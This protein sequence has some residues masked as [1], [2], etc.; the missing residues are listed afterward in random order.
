MT[1]TATLLNEGRDLI[2]GAQFESHT[3]TSILHVEECATGQPELFS[4]SAVLAK[5]ASTGIST[6]RV[7]VDSSF[8]VGSGTSW[9]PLTP[10][11]EFG[12]WLCRNI[13]CTPNPNKKNSWV[14]RITETNMGRVY[15]S[16]AADDSDDPGS[17]S[18]DQD[19]TVNWTATGKKQQAW[20]SQPELPEEVRGGVNPDN[21]YEANW[22]NVWDFCTSV[23]DLGGDDVAFGM[24]QPIQLTTRQSS[25][26][27]EWIVRAPIKDFDGADMTPYVNSND[28][29]P[30][31]ALQTLEAMV[32]KRSWQDIG[33]YEAGY[34]LMDNISVQPLHYEFKRVI[35]TLTYDEWKHA[36]QRPWTTTSGVVAGSIGCSGNDEEIAD[37]ATEIINIGALYVGWLQPYMRAFSFGDEPDML[38]NDGT[39]SEI[40]WKL[41]GN[42]S[43]YDNDGG[44]EC[45]D[46]E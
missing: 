11:T 15:T 39:M 5:L 40:F 37:G 35:M 36:F 3:Q 38:F 12:R 16:G 1:I 26:Q 22:C 13:S 21:V 28:V 14:V 45:E 18:G 30:Y 42:P 43:T 8:E 23:D 44:G 46:A 20:R 2:R 33:S 10:A 7:K 24:A 27:V 17:F 32:G 9:E 29:S 25:I 4:A 19:V 6:Y 31:L 41:G 34:L